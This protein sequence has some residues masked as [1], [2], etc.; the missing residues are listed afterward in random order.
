MPGLDGFEVL[1][2]V[3][4]EKLAMPVIVLT[5][6][7][8]TPQEQTTLLEGMVKIL[9]KDSDAIQHV[10][11][12]AKRF[13]SSRHKTESDRLPRILY[14]EDSAQNRD[15]VRRYL[16]GVFEVI[17][18]EDGEQGL[19]RVA[20]HK[21]NLILMDLSLPRLDGY[22]ATRRLKA[23]AKFATIP[24]LALTAHAAKEDEQRARAAGCIE[25]LTKPIGRDELVAAIQRNLAGAP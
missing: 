2:T 25:Y 11:D 20:Q 5:G 8:L 7:T 1:R 12:E 23:D 19:E 6:K 3:R 14:V 18:A 22:E 16:R 15:L 9:H 24:V 21:P 10:I 17:E 4:A 13:I